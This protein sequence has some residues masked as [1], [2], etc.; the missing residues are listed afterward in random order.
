MD[1]IFREQLGSEAAMFSTNSTALCSANA[2]MAQEETMRPFPLQ[3]NQRFAI[4]KI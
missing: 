1:F 4:L 3:K 2:S